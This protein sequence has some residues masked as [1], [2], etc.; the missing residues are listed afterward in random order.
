MT[1]LTFPQGDSGGPLICN[2]VLAGIVSFN[3]RCALKDYPTVYVNVG[4]YRQ[5]IR[6]HTE[7]VPGEEDRDQTE[8]AKGETIRTSMPLLW[9]CLWAIYKNKLN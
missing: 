5:W 2:T 6:K 4:R 9:I 1:I 7:S 3:Y 8:E